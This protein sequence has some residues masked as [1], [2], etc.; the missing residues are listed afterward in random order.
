MVEDPLKDAATLYVGNLFV[1]PHGRKLLI[2]HAYRQV[3]LYNRG[4]NS[5]VIC[6]VSVFHH[7]SRSDTDVDIL[8]VW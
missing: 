3:I 2:A 6:K 7:G 1:H 4:A 5:R 8:Q